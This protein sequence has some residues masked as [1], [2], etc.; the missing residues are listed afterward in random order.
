MQSHIAQTRTRRTPSHPSTDIQAGGSSRQ[1]PLLSHSRSHVDVTL[2]HTQIPVS[3]T[4]LKSQ[5]FFA[6]VLRFFHRERPSFIPCRKRCVYYT[7]KDGIFFCKS[8]KPREWVRFLN[9]SY[10]LHPVMFHVKRWRNLL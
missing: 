10:Y 3:L 5:N 8:G 6:S 4:S 2:P 1:R 9:C 7:E